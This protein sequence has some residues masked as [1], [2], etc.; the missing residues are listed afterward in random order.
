MLENYIIPIHIESQFF[1]DDTYQFIKAAK[2]LENV[3]EDLEDYTE[4]QDKH[5]ETFKDPD[6][7]STLFKPAD[8]EEK[9]ELGIIQNDWIYGEIVTKDTD[10]FSFYNLDALARRKYFFSAL[11]VLFPLHRHVWAKGTIKRLL[12]KIYRD[13]DKISDTERHE[14]NKMIET[15][16]ERENDTSRRT[17][18]DFEFLDKKIMSS[19]GKTDEPI[20]DIRGNRLVVDGLGAWNSRQTNN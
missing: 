20:K 19:V 17:H 9:N 7:G 5:L 15:I 1:T 12:Q 10:G 18:K 4:E 13:S 2:A 3:F 6:E 16:E 14:V 11:K 8:T